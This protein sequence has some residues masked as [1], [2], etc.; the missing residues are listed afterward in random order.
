MAEKMAALDRGSI[1]ASGAMSLASPAW[2]NVC[3]E[4]WSQC[5]SSSGKPNLNDVILINLAY[6]SDV[7]I[8]NDRTETPPP[9]ASLNV[10]K[11]GQ[12]KDKLSQA[13]AISAGVSVEGQ[14]LFQTIHK[15]IKDCKWQEKNII[16]MD[17]VV[18]SPPYQVENCKGKEGSA[19]ITETDGHSP[20]KL[21]LWK[22]VEEVG[23]R[24]CS[25]G[26]KSSWVGAYL[27][28]NTL[29]VEKH[30]RDVESQKSMQ[31][32]QAQ[33]TQKDSTLSS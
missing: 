30:F 32:S 27:P 24:C 29:H 10:S 25:T 12:K 31:R 15:T 19:L 33:Q 8:I 3:K 22:A 28:I 18:I 11:H 21:H 20:P 16:V 9:L 26:R 14:Q 13:Y 2:A 1:S 4:K 6:V 7:D 17:D 23:F 5:A